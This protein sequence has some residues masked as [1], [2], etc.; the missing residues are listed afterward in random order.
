MS[1]MYEQFKE[2]AAS[3][4]A[5]EAYN[6]FDHYNCAIAQFAKTVDADFE[7]A[8]ITHWIS[9]DPNSLREYKCVPILDTYED[10]ERYSQLYKA[11]ATS[12]TFGELASNL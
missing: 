1:N 4:P 8:G 11:V 5:D 6:V 12:L 3:K 2:F 10:D 9:N 7:S